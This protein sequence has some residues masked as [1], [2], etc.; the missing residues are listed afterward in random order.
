MLFGTSAARD[1]G[2]ALIFLGTA[3]GS[4][5][6]SEGSERGL[7]EGPHPSIIL[8]LPGS[9]NKT[10]SLFPSCLLLTSWKEL[11]EQVACVSAYFSLGK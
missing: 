9:E 1:R 4:I 7:G 3:L 5:P 2:G 10:E 11:G 8:R 6:T